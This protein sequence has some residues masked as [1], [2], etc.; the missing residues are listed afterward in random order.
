MDRAG[1]TGVNNRD[2]IAPLGEGLLDHGNIDTR[3]S[4]EEQNIAV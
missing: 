4:N 2:R 1:S 3:K